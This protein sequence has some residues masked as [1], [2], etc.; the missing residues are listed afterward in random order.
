MDAPNPLNDPG[1]IPVLGVLACAATG[2][3]GSS[4]SSMD[5]VVTV[6]ETL[7][8]AMLACFISAIFPYA[9]K[10][11][12]P[13]VAW[14]LAVPCSGAIGLCIYGVAVLVRKSNE[15]VGKINPE[16]IIKDKTGLGE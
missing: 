9:L 13:S 1:N 10:A 8:H 14:W 3:I 16:K 2:A 12:W 6:R 4:I 11:I 7:W 5:R 15:A